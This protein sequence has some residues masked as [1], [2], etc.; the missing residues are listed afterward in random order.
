[1]MPIRGAK[2]LRALG[3]CPRDGESN[4]GGVEFNVQGACMF[5]FIGESCKNVSFLMCLQILSVTHQ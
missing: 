4:W 5:S 2:F 1:M 3:G